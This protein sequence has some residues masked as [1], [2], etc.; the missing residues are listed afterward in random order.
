M[1]RHYPTISVDATPVRGGRPVHAT[2]RC[3]ME[4]R[5]RVT[6]NRV[7]I[8]RGTYGAPTLVLYSAADRV[9]I[10]N[11]CSIAA[12]CYL[13]AGG[14]HNTRVTSTFPFK[15]YY[16]QDPGAAAPDPA[17]IRYADAVY[18]GA[19]VI[20][21]DVWI[22]FGATVLSC[23]TIGHGAVVGAGA[24]VASSVPPFAIVV[25]NPARILRYRFDDDIVAALLRIQWWHWQPDRVAEYQSLLQGDPAQFVEAVDRL[26]FE[27]LAAYR[28]PD[29]SSDVLEY[30]PGAGLLRRPAAMARGLAR[31][32]V[33]PALA[34]LSRRW[35]NTWRSTPPGNTA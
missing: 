17:Q 31:H 4:L 24:V 12:G 26:H 2:G 35:I 10:G 9:V 34:S 19:L 14:E 30:E 29:P 8:G 1:T 23:V 15:V 13:L 25:G 7:S 6:D 11:Y 16:G 18:K 27:T 33:P 32:V 3:H 20:G 22:G 28:G 21:S 5:W